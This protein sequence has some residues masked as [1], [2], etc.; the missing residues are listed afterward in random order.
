M[1]K[2]LLPPQC[3]GFGWQQLHMHVCGTSAWFDFKRGAW[4]AWFQCVG[5]HTLLFCDTYSL[6][7]ASCRCWLFRVKAGGSGML[8]CSSG[9]WMVLS[10]FFGFWEQGGSCAR[11]IFSC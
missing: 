5:S 2:T 4:V 9:L 11:F 10:L 7:H 3:V 1:T 6:L 8:V